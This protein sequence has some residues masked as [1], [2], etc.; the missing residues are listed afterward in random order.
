LAA[1]RN[2]GP[3][4]LTTLKKVPKAQ[5]GKKVG[6]VQEVYFEGEPFHG[7][8]TRVF[9]YYTRPATGDGPFPAV[10][11]VHG[12]GGTAYAKWANLWAKRGY[13]AL[14]MDLAGHGPDK[15]QRLTDGGPDQHDDTKFGE[16]DDQS[17]KQMWTY[18]AVAAVI[19]GHSLLASRK[20][21]DA[22][23][24][25]ITG[26]SWGGY[27]TCIVAGLDDRLKVAAPVY[28]CGFLH[29]NSVWMP[30]FKEMKPEQK[31]RWVKNFDPSQY[32][33]GVECPILFVNGTN[34]FAYPLDS[35]Q[36]SY[37]AVPG[38]T[39][40]CVKIRMQHSHVDGWAPQEIGLYFDS[41]LTAGK[42]LAK[43][44]KVNIAA[45][46]ATATFKSQVP[47]VSAQWHFTTDVGAWQ[48]RNWKSIEAQLDGKIIT[49]KLPSQ[50][51]LVGYFTV[52]DQRGAMI[53]T[54]HVELPK[55]KTP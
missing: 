44:S 24:V 39:D 45:E 32:L 3:W 41:V 36:K 49:V 55:A 52:R 33:P 50:R 48:K 10:V 34:D 25:G 12:G 40:L 18:H 22:S 54:E 51:P 27:L 37:R 13:V 15:K 38:K 23:R 20:E 2:T 46:V 5:W 6:P 42:P 31:D 1:E 9:A 16:F 29:H 17:V 30:R 26:I 4:D 35:Y 53:S 28:G 21:V 19:R 43:I 11:L 7:K 47:V 14:A 8:P